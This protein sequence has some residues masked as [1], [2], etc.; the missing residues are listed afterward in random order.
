MKTVCLTTGP[1]G[2][3]CYLL[4]E[5]GKGLVIDPG[6]D[7]ERILWEIQ[8]ENVTLE[9]ILLTHGHFDHIGGIEA[10]T[11]A[12]PDVPVLISKADLPMLSDPQK[13]GSLSLSGRGITVVRGEA[14]AAFVSFAGKEIQVIP[15]PGHTEG[16]CC[17]LVENSLFTGDTLFRGSVGR[18]DLYGGDSSELF[19]SL[20]KLKA[21]PDSLL[22]FPGHG[23]E[24]TLGREKRQ[25]PFLEV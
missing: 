11:D 1:I 17:F 9:T 24:T 21:L 18:T 13:N 20:E 7:G 16:S 4:I 6:G 12:F 3:N 8:K 5:E 10:L 22:V 25:N 14:L 23:A 15:T 2:T 19:Y